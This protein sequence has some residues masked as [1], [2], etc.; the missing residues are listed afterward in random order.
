M[1]TPQIE[2]AQLQEGEN[3][4]ERDFYFYARTQQQVNVL[5]HQ[6][7]NQL[8]IINLFEE[9]LSLGRR[10]CQELRNRLGI[11]LGRIEF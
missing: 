9:I 2:E 1:Q 4:Y 7:W 6:Q 5:L 3:L 10:E 11:L 8:D